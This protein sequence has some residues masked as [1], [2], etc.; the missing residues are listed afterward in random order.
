MTTYV[1][2]TSNWNDPLFWAS[3]NETVGG[4]EL[5][6]SG[7]GAAFS[8]DVD[9]AS[10]II[11]IS[12]GVTP[13][14]VGE[15]GVA[16]T[17]ANFGGT[18]LLDFFT[19]IS[20]A[21]GDDTVNGT[22]GNDTLD[23]NSG[24]DSVVGD[25]GAD[26]IFGNGGADTLD[27]GIGDD[28]IFAG[29][30]NDSLLGGAGADR[31]LGENDNDTIDGGAGDDTIDGGSGSDSLIGDLGSDTILGGDGNDFLTGSEATVG[32]A[33]IGGSETVSDTFTVIRLGNFEDVD[34]DEID[35]VSENAAD[36][37]GS[38]GSFGEEIYT[39]FETASTFDSNTDS[40]LAD[41]DAG[42]T[43]ENI[44]IGGVT[45]QLD[46][47]QVYDAT[48]L[49]TDGTSG[50]F[51]AVVSQTTTGETFLM[52]E[53]EIDTD[54]ALLTSKPIL[55][56]SLDT[57]T[58]DDSG[59][60]AERVDADF[61]VPLSGDTAG[62]SIE[63]GAGED[64]IFGDLG[65]D[66]LLGGDGEDIISGGGDDDSLTGGDGNDTLFGG[67]GNDTLDGGALDDSLVGGDGA[68][69]L[70]GG[71]GNDTLIA[72]TG[73][74]TLLG[75]DGNDLL[76]RGGNDAND[77][78]NELSGGAGDDTI[79]LEDGINVNDQIDGGDGIDTLEILP[80]DGRNLTVTMD[81]GVNGNV[82]DGTIGTQE[83]VN[84]ENI[85]TG[86]GDDTI[87]GD[88]VDNAI[89]SGAG[90]DSIEGGAGADVLDG[91]DGTDTIL[92]GTGDDTIISTGNNDSII[93]GDD[94]DFIQISEFE[95][96]GTNSVTIDGGSGGTD[97]DVLD[98]SG[99]LA[100]GWTIINLTQNPDGAGAP[101]I[102]G[103]IQLSRGP[104]TATINF[105]DI[106][107]LVDVPPNYV[108]EGTD[109]ADLIDGTYVGDPEADLV[110]AGDSAADGDD[111]VILARLGD[112]TVNSGLGDDTV[113]GGGGADLIDGGAGDDI[114][115]G[116]DGNIDP[117][118]VENAG[119]DSGTTG[120]SVTGSGTIVYAVSGDPELTFNA[121]NQGTGG[122]LE[123]TVNTETGREYELSVDV[124][125]YDEFGGVG[126]HTLV[127]EVIDTNGNVIATRTDVITDESDQTLTLSFTSTTEDVTLRF[128][129]PTSTATTDTDLRIDNITVTEVAPT[130][131]GN[132]TIDGGDGNDLIYG[133]EGADSLS[134]G[135]GDDT[136]AGDDF[137]GNG[138]N[139]IVNGSFEDTTGMNLAGYGYNDSDGS[140]TG[141]TDANGF[142]I[143]FHNDE[144]GGLTATDGANWMDMEAA[145]GQQNVIS[146][147]V[148]GVAYGEV[149]VLS[150]D[151][152]DYPDGND[153]T[154][155][156]NQLQVIWN[157]DVIATIDPS[158]G[159]WDSHE[160]YV[161]G[162]SG[163]GTD[164]LTFAG[165]GNPD[166][167]GVSLDNVQMYAA[168]EDAGGADSI[169]GGDGSD[170][171]LGGAG[172]DTLEGGDGDDLILGGTGDDSLVAGNNTGAGDT[173]LGGAGDDTLTDSFWN[174][175][176]DGGAGSDLINAGYGTA[177]VIGGE[178]ASD[179][180]TLSF[181]LAD[182]VVD[183]TF[184]ANEAG[185][186]LDS[187]GDS[188]TFTGIESFV[189]TTGDDTLDAS[190]AITP[191]NVV[192]GDGN[193][194][195]IGGDGADSVLAGDGNDTVAG[196]A[197]ADT[198]DGGLGNNTLDYSGSSG[199]FT[200]NL[201]TNTAAGSDADGD[202]ISNFQNV[203][204]SN[205]GDTITLSATDGTIFAGTGNDFLQGGT[206]ND[207]ILGNAGNDTINGGLGND[208]LD[209]GADNDQFVSSEGADTILGGT[210][211]DDYFA[212]DGFDGDVVDLGG[213]AITINNGNAEE[214]ISVFNVTTSVDIVYTSATGGTATSGAG[215]SL[216]FD[217][218]DGFEGAFDVGGTFDASLAGFDVVFYDYGGMTSVV[219]SDY[220]D[221]LVAY[222][223]DP[224]GAPTD[225]FYDGGAGND[226][227]DTGDGNDTILGGTG[228]DDIV[229][230][231]GDDVISGG[232]GADTIFGGDGNDSINGGSGG[233]SLLGGA[234]NDTIVT[235]TGQDT[236]FGGAGNDSILANTGAND[237]LVYGEDGA[238]TIFGSSQN[239]TLDGGADADVIYAGNSF[240]LGNDSI[241][242][243]ETVTTGTD[244]D[245][246]D[247]STV[248]TGVTVDWT[249]PEAGT[250]TDGADTINFSDI[251]QIIL[252]DQADLLDAASETVGVNVDGAGGND[253]LNTGSGNDTV[254]GGDGTNSYSLG[255]GDDVMLG[256]TGAD[257]VY[258]FDGHGDDTLDGGAG[259]D[260]LYYGFVTSG[261][262]ITFD[263]ATGGTATGGGDT[264]SFDNF[265]VIGLTNV[266]D[267]IDAT[268]ATGD[269]EILSG[270]G[271]DTVLTGSG[272]DSIF[273]GFGTTTSDVYFDGGAG[274]D[275]IAGSDGND[276]LI[277]GLGEDT[278]DGGA[279]ADSIEGGAG[280]D[281]I[282][283]GAGDGFVDTVVFADGDGDDTIAGFEAPI[284]NGDGT[285]T[286][287][288]QLDLSGLTDVNGAPV[289]TR[290]VTVTDDGLGNALLS[291]PNS[292]TVTLVGIAPGDVTSDDALAA[293]GI[294]QS[295]DVVSGTAGGDLIDA[296]YLGDAQ[297]DMVDAGDSATG[298]DDDS[299]EA[300]DG[301]DT[302]AAGAGDDTVL[303]GAGA[304]EI[305]GGIGNDS[306]DAGSEN[307]TVL[308]WTGNDSIAGG[309]GDDSIF[310]QDGNDTILG[311]AG[312]DYLDGDD[313]L[314]GAD[315]IFGEAGNDTIIGDGGNDTLSGGD[316]ND[317]IF[318]GADD[319]SVSGGSGNDNID[320]GTGNDRIEA[321]AGDD[322]VSGG[323]GNDTIF[324]FEGSDSVLGGAGD[325]VINTRTSPGTGVPDEGYGAPGDTGYY[326]AD[327]SSI[328]DRDYV[329]GG[330]DNDII[331]TGDDN[332]TIIGGEGADTINAGF[333]DDLISGN[334]GADS[335]E[336]NEG[337]DT[338]DGGDNADI[339]YGDVSPDNPDYGLFTPYDLPND[340]TDLAPGNNADSIVGG[341]GNDTIYGQDDNDTLF[342]DAGDDL[343]DGGQDNDSLDGGD[344]NDTLIGGLGA[345]SMFGGS[346]DD[347]FRIEDDFGAD[348][349]DGSGTVETGGDTIDASAVTQ[350][351][352]LDLSQGDAG[353][354]ESGTLDNGTSTASFT[355]IESVT[356]GDGND[357]V[358]GSTGAD[359]VATGGGDDTVNAGDGADNLD[360]GDG[361]D[362]VI[363][364]QG[365][366]VLGGTGDDFFTLAD[367]DTTGTGNAA[368]S[369]TGGEGGETGGDT[370]QLTSDVS[371]A[372]ITFS[373]T[374]DAAGGL[375]GSF[376]MADGTLVT[377]AEVE[378]IICFTPGTRIL[379]GQGERAIETLQVGDLVVTR[380]QGLRPIRWI[381][382]RTVPGQGRFAPVRV[383]A[384]ALDH[385]RRGLLVSQQHRILF[386]GYR[387]ELL[388]GDP[389]VLVAAK[390]LVD[391]RDVV[392]EPCGEVTYIHMMFDHHEVIYAEGIATE[393]FH[394]GDVGLSAV[395]GP[396]RE[397]L[398]S[399]FPELRSA[400]GHHLETARQCLKKHEAQLLVDDRGSDSAYA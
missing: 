12:D 161:V 34:P 223:A 284:D 153:D 31:L 32:S 185:S 183:V 16:G 368:I 200:V 99:L 226:T 144:R 392:E 227:L 267:S 313:A 274:D 207:S 292:Q 276:T 188:G 367:L 310:G 262:T 341:G 234:G 50:T 177:T 70:I 250:I 139:L 254:A 121:N 111:D 249:G 168:V 141:W 58:N 323:D 343:L 126:D 181:A 143:D 378:N 11:T 317:L 288:D 338:I 379:T 178:S 27:G 212:S 389:E 219:G 303:G 66:T 238:D 386:T 39:K 142:A 180:D 92:G 384:N 321:D 173:L 14:T 344:G 71:I 270:E 221:L 326:P 9:Q 375:S 329:D 132:D 18:T 328:N 201:T 353:S 372:D 33:G 165:L 311:G 41:N 370:L 304:D 259:R 104:E 290:D 197:G 316:D 156:D 380:D 184:N 214:F 154:A 57:L 382:Q 158:D 230:R 120:W 112:D 210:G 246:L 55:S 175:T 115:Y 187:D 136:V 131:A 25:T 89:L 346:G 91:G 294:L 337:N 164:T 53:F 65:N 6:F 77:V 125:E 129:N 369:I 182:D 331:L 324:G 38:Y 355:E 349:I 45:Y 308:G 366:T 255:A 335:I 134:G 287:Q 394:A 340:G 75:G 95:S 35:G 19:T 228:D 69:S 203:I 155:L 282:D 299:I 286:G 3:L 119:F 109:N 56:V 232:A 243:G 231:A 76:I 127:M 365:D 51:T 189:L 399:I 193:D 264:D 130:G 302:V 376:T 289:N 192:A 186:Y 44:V 116:D 28:E 4:H 381:G 46:S 306:I 251:E 146:Q 332:D 208:T 81:A 72:G 36:L 277:G 102:S 315:E 118:Y 388:F 242:G 128:S 17:D 113:S 29:E 22:I 263:S 179:N 196:G 258:Q 268:L 275:S 117:V 7:L 245:T 352:T 149:Y 96:G 360:L 374:D 300:G 215:E 348:T 157:G 252:T 105:T 52:P 150:F 170:E 222:G 15:S 391:G 206:G 62:D 209:G 350:D 49:F 297:G 312:A 160:F 327:P 195:I 354:G 86:A 204:G 279:G 390:H 235:G 59:L 78:L 133:N 106:E 269:L 190:A 333:D 172:N 43:P 205:F 73:S 357:D 107:T 167:I 260:E 103:Q 295:D 319:D 176:L 68:D 48:V 88:A 5:D 108:V 396:A 174:S 60:V 145:A 248:T 296:T 322:T 273:T 247:L 82:V 93:G 169:T 30:G 320:G 80:A 198:L 94:A 171:L 37:L 225:R 362:S 166:G 377:F 138:P 191:V 217:N 202:V 359:N 400:P 218:V 314:A 84:V 110:D 318:A 371:S 213:D 342:G 122:T 83:Y 240:G 233:D 291:F 373:N 393:S 397:E 147:S 64:T 47:T 351:L 40:T 236:V 13:F 271:Q 101:G 54:H 148:S 137:S 2:T 98:I 358:I 293:M 211:R 253:T 325:D 42:A 79:R 87:F 395:S 334:A 229:A 272:N 24:D 265:E 63:G 363:V 1:V 199:S 224:T 8:V 398:F 298:T 159:N 261:Q 20:G 339:I 301:N 278:L 266:D 309:T 347:V 10:G 364:D 90:D 256:G 140:V 194:S 114:L 74:D 244:F 356:L 305:D 26:T 237:K 21:Q 285:F 135:I 280:N 163:D 241:T 361:N 67:T 61:Q 239:D 307:D 216:T 283:V 385:A 124:S 383:G 151:V 345:D 281:S 97:A 23:G 330:L 220:N 123:Q 152:G 387:A 100:D 162:G 336:G 85:T 257:L